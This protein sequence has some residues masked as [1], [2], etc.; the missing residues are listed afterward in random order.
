MR[1]ESK[2]PSTGKQLIK[3][4]TRNG[5]ACRQYNIKSVIQSFLHRS[6]QICSSYQ[7]IHKEFQ[8]IKFCFLSNGYPDWF[9]DKQIKIFLNKRYENTTSKKKAR[10]DD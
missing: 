1:S 6:C 7:L 9:I 10:K 4:Y 8:H 2:Q 5:K 3:D